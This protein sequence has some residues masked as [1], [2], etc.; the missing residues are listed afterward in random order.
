MRYK[1]FLYSLLS[2]LLLST[3]WPTWGFSPL[4][5]VAFVP[6]MIVQH[7]ISGDTRW[8]AWHLFLY[9]Y[10]S[11]LIWNCL[12]TWWVWYASDTG[13]LLAFL[14][15]SLL[16]GIVFIIFHKLK[17]NLPERIGNFVLIPVW[18]T[19]EWLHLDWDLSWPWLTLGNAFASDYKW[20]QW[21]EYTGVFGGSL[22]ILLINVLVFQLIM[23][24]NTLLRPLKK[25][26]TYLTSLATLLILPIA[27]SYLIYIGYD[28]PRPMIKPIDVTVIQPNIDPY[29]K[30]DTDFQQQ[31]D[32]MLLL[33]AQQTDNSSDYLVFPETA[34]VEDIWENK[35]KTSSSIVHLKKFREQ[36]PHLNLVTG[37]STSYYYEPG[38]TRSPTARKFSDADIWYES[39]NTALQINETDSTAV[40]HKSKLVP[41]VERMPFPR[42]LGWLGDYAID[43]GGTTGSL[44]IQNERT[45]FCSKAACIAPVIC[46]ESVYGDYVAQYIRNGADYIFIMTNDGWWGNTPGYKQHLAY[47]RLR[48]IETRKSIARSANTG[49]SCFINH[50]GDIEQAQTWWQPTAVRQRISSVE[51]LTF[52][53]RF[54]DYIAIGM[55]GITS[56]AILWVIIRLG[57]RRRKT[58]SDKSSS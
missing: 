31:L 48:A 29:I 57:T 8:R 35:I 26:V 9:S 1:L 46:Y 17:R 6:L 34:L 52:Y 36:F 40:Y 56:I 28:T 49:I 21:Y 3:G 23:Y 44:G 38:E 22:W 18:I 4:L 58:H 25:R 53:V 42:W 47:G 33:A 55:A 15:N 16:M 39:Y 45:V 12:T 10:L 2:G 20:I 30:F 19:F 7:I 14:A 41:G 24:R 43:L 51:G 37:A 5:F 32:A 54:G 13:S 27:C 11:F 50:K